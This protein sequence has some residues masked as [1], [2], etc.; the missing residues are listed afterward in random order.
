VPRIIKSTETI[1]IAHPN[2]TIYGQIGIGKTSL[3]YSM[4]KPLLLDFDSGAHRAV[5]RKDTLVVEQWSD[6]IEMLTSGRLVPYESIVVDTVG[7]CLDVMTADIIMQTPKLGPNGNLSQQGWGVLKTRFRQWMAQLRAQNKDVLLIAH[8][9]E[10]RDGD[11]RTVRPDIAGG[12]LGEVM[13]I[14]DF[15]GYIAM[16]GKDRVLD[17]SPTD[18]WIGK[19]PAGWPQLVLPPIVDA[20]VFMG[21]L[22]DK[23]RAA[24][25]KISDANAETVDLIEQWRLKIQSFKADSDFNNTIP[26]IRELPKPTYK[27]IATV[28]VQ[29]A[30]TKGLSYDAKKQRFEPAA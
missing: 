21:D 17:F 12:S 3:G 10:E 11:L 18:R 2:I 20:K 15:V 30:E 9:R 4:K 16:N 27:A 1:A 29:I 6:V 24:L 25:G 28:L 26:I 8:D 23:A 19:N 22:Y 13:K 14:S 7:R 5:N